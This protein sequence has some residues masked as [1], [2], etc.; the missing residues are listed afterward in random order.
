MTEDTKRALE[1]IQPIAEILNFKVSATDNLLFMNDQAIGI[2]C[3]STYATLFEM[4][5][6]IFWEKW[7]DHR[8]LRDDESLEETIKRYWVSKEKLK[9]LG[10]IT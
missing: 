1:I 7:L 6:W 3:N 10:V 8:P 5:G 2:S 4:I 9:K